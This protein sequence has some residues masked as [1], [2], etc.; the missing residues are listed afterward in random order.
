MKPIL[1]RIAAACLL[2]L[3]LGISAASA[4]TTSTNTTTYTT[5]T[6]TIYE[7][8]YNP[9]SLTVDEYSTEILAL[10]NGSIIY[11][12]TFALA[13]SDPTVQ[14]A[15]QAAE[16]LLAADNA[17]FGAPVLTS[18]S[19]ALAS[20]VTANSAPVTT[21]TDVS[22]TTTMYIGPQTIMVGDNQSQSF[23]IVPGG[24]DYD[25]LVTSDVHQS[26]DVVTT[27]TYL[28]TQFWQIDGVTAPVSS[29]PDASSTGLMLGGSLVALG[30]FARRKSPMAAHPFSG[31]E[32]S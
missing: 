11:D 6:K 23:T 13:F 24:I 1:L 10:L 19:T 29:V 14:A 16:A 26:I 21:G 20:S 15:V 27:N 28:T 8:T 22:F 30:W 17:T 12:Q 3:W 25:T 18:A 2:P 5:S 4:Q 7:D 9:L 31:C 32:D